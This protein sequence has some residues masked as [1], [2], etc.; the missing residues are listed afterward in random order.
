MTIDDALTVSASDIQ[1]GLAIRSPDL[2]REIAG[3][4]ELTLCQLSPS[5]FRALVAEWRARHK[6]APRPKLVVTPAPRRIGYGHS[7]GER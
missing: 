6:G 4:L 3:G 5:E 1:S 7:R 2:A